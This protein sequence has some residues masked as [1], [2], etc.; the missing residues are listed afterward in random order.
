MNPSSSPAMHATPSPLRRIQDLP[1]PFAWPL[2]GNLL[3]TRPRRLHRDLERWGREYGA[4]YRLRIGRDVVLV[5]SDH[6]VIN[7]VLRD[8]PDVFRRPSITADVSREMGGLPG[9][10]LAEGAMWRQQRRMVMP[11]F[12]AHAIK[13]YFPQLLRVVA[14]L[15]GRWQQAAAGGRPIDLAADLK[16]YTVDIIAG[17]AFGHEVN[18]LETGDD[19]IQ[20][21]LDEVMNGVARRSVMPIPYWRLIRLPVDRRLERGVKALRE[22][23]DG[24]IAQARMRMEAEP[25]RRTQP[26]NLLESM[27]NAADEAGSEAGELNVAGNVTTM[28]LAGEDTTA[29]SLVW[30]LYLLRQHPA[31]LRQAQEEVLR[32]APDHSAFTLEQIDALSYLEACIHESMRLKPVAPFIPLEALRDTVVGEVRVPKGGQL[33]CLMRQDGVDEKHVSNAAEFDPARWLADRG[34]SAMSKGT[35]LPFGAGPRTCPGRYLA[36][37]EIKLAAAMLLS[38]FDVLSIETPSG[39]QAEERM[40]FVMSASKLHMRLARRAPLPGGNP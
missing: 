26:Q 3:Q 33:I 9:V 15:H 18:T 35:T 40:G 4:F 32:I 36:L 39:A 23:V 7:R 37:L 16:R 8:R 19:V 10:F 30:L 12:S 22:A 1:G 14:R 5:V 34:E 21:H 27:I 17:L 13:A 25:Q 28:L 11:A 29:N 38:R 20:Q 24:F 31:A 2:F 6:A